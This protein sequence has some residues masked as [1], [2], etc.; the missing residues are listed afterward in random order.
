MYTMTRKDDPYIKQFYRK[1]RCCLEF[2][3][4]LNIL[5]TS[6]VILCYI[7]ITIYSL[8]TVHILRLFYKLSNVLNFIETARSI[9][10][11]VWYIF[12]SNSIKFQHNW[13]KRG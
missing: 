5:C 9:Y 8:F 6:L 13:S 7:K 11:N 3:S 4:Q 1:Q 2:W 10:Q 12:T